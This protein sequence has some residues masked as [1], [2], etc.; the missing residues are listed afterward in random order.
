MASENPKY[1][2]KPIYYGTSKRTPMYYGSSQG[3]MPY[4]YGGSGGNYGRAP[5]YYG[6]SSAQDSDSLVGTITPARVLRV[7]SQRWISVLVF[8]LVGLVA[9]FAV[10]RISPTIYEA[11]SEFT[12]QMRGSQ[13]SQGTLGQMTEID[14]GNTYEE[15]FNTRLS[16]WRSEKIVT[17][18]MQ[19]YRANFPASTVS[20][21]ELVEALVES[22]L[23]LIRHSRLITIAVRS[24][25]PN[26]AAALANAYAEAIESFT[27]EENKLRCDKAVAQIHE[28]VEKQRRMDEKVAAKLLEFRTTHKVDNL[29]SEREILQQSLQK[30]TTDVLALETE[31]TSAAEWEKVLE[32]AQETPEDFG[33]LPSAVPRSTEIGQAYTDL[34]K[35]QMELNS[36]LISFTKNHPEVRAKQKELDILKQQFTE[37]VSRA[38]ATAHGN[39]AAFRNQ[40]AVH[41]KNRDR[42]TMSLAEIDQ[43]I[44]SAESGLLQIESEKEISSQ[45]L[46]QLQQDENTAR[47]AAEA[48][49]EIV[50]VGRPANVPSKPVLPNPIVIFAVGIAASLVMGL[51]FVLVLDHLEDTIVSLADIETR[52]ALKV[53]AVL[54]HVR[55]K[56]REEVARF[57]SDNKYSQFAEAVAGLR[58][59]LDSPRYSEINK[60]LLIMST[61]PGEGKSIT[62][63][64]LAISNAQAHRK[65]LLVD[66]D[67][68]RPRLARVWGLTSL[69]KEHSFSHNLQKGSEC[70][71]AALVNKSGI[72]N[73]DVIASL[74]P[75]GV[76]PASIMGSNIVSEFFAWAREHY[77]RIV[78]DSPPFGI[79]GDVMT[80]A[81][82]VDGVMIMCCPDRTHFRPIQSA[83]RNLAEA[84]ATVLGIIVNDVETGAM[85]GAFSQ[86]GHYAYGYRK[87]G[88]GYG[89]GYGYRPNASAKKSEEAA[90][91][92]TDEE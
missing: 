12:V 70:D 30:V 73:L 84:G 5:Y 43:K 23:E 6:G 32:A 7:I 49:N 14:Y 72:A 54:P 31:V 91:T 38:L 80:L 86:H 18:I 10:Y 79:V 8:L 9:S 67:L 25:S 90:K 41:K 77:D 89:Y 46:K 64:S 65:T 85:S 39:L 22:Q 4:Y 2:G 71:F 78:I 24:S 87:Y 76:D 60:V 47:I 45:L 3:A 75:E 16:D 28:Q 58:N 68:R 21:Q 52:L 83:A 19:Q 74:Q 34:Q 33:A 36:L 20:D 59:L 57:I 40:L 61:Q 35:C 66:F 15:V 42:L 92:V 62:S 51:I 13:S 55:R 1:G 63:C 88:Y 50:R 56:K 26:L 17:K 11:K 53:L 81:A 48:N 29:R 37:S 82:M 27:D 44:I 69:D